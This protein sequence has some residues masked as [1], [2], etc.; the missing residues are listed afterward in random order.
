MEGAGLGGKYHDFI[1]FDLQE[2]KKHLGLY[3]LKI[4]PHLRRLIWATDS[5]E[6]LTKVKERDDRGE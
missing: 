1:N 2:F 6:E 5:D 3:L 4:Y